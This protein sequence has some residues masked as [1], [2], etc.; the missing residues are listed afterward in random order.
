MNKAEH[1]RE[2]VKKHFWDMPDDASLTT[3]KECVLPED[4]SEFI[5]EYADVLSVDMSVFSF[6]RYFPNDGI[7]FLPN[8]ILPKYLQTDHHNPAPLTVEML[9]KSAEAGKWLY[10]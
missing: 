7:R 9:I 8:A 6:R 10:Q 3:G 1:V 4:A 5:E 2:L